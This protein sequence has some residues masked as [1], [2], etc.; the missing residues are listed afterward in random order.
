MSKSEYYLVIYPDGEW[1]WVEVTSRRQLLCRFYEVI[2]CDCVEHVT[3]PY[4]FGCIVDE[5]GKLKN[6]PQPYN[7]FASRMYP[8][9]P[10][11]DPLVGPVIFVR[12]DLVDGE[13]DWCPILPSDLAKIRLITGLNIDEMYTPGI[14]L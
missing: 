5:S 7:P 4:G 9:T 14:D 1:K 2:D 10:Y 13:Y 6:P 12:T 8:G 11:G 3:L